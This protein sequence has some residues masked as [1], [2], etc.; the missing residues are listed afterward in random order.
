MVDVEKQIER[1]NALIGPGYKAVFVSCAEE[2]IAQ[3]YWSLY[4]E[5]VRASGKNHWVI[6]RSSTRAILE[7]AAVYEAL[8]TEIKLFE[9]DPNDFLSVRTA[10]LSCESANPISGKAQLLPKLAQAARSCDTYLHVDITAGLGSQWIDFDACRPDYITYQGDEMGSAVLWVEQEAP[11]KPLLLGYGG[12][13]LRSGGVD[14]VLVQKL[15]DEIEHKVSHLPTY[16]IE[17]SNL[18]EQVMSQLKGALIHPSDLPHVLTF[19]YTDIHGELLAFHLNQ[20]GISAQIGGESEVPLS[21]LIDS[22]CAVSLDLRT[23]SSVKSSQVAE[24]IADIA[25]ELSGRVAL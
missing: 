14:P 25:G 21:S 3:V 4:F 15:A 8:G 22:E 1:L 12:Q 6:S 23:L 17:M 16:A 7:T 13:V 18:R 11:I 10:L 9:S 19:E 5:S 24:R 2:A 20:A